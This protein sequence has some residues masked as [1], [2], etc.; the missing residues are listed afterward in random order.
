[1]MQPTAAARNRGRLGEMIAQEACNMAT[2]GTIDLL[3]WPRGPS[4]PQELRGGRIGH[5]LVFP[6]TFFLVPVL[7]TARVGIKGRQHDRPPFSLS[8]GL[9]REKP[10]NR[11]LED[12]SNLT[13]QKTTGVGCNGYAQPFCTG[14]GNLLGSVVRS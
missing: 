3:T 8:Q 12:S 6:R 13:R 10:A 9:L 7:L 11:L 5:G 1:M 14:G 4:N 2:L